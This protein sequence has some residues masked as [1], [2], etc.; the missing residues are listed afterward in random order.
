MC[1][2]D[3]T[4]RHTSKLISATQVV[5]NRRG[6]LQRF[7]LKTSALFA[8]SCSHWSQQSNLLR[9]QFQTDDPIMGIICK[10][11]CSLSCMCCQ[12]IIVDSN[13]A[14]TTV[15]N[16]GSCFHGCRIC[17]VPFRGQAVPNSCISSSQHYSLL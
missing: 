14:H 13:A 2:D 4:S 3:R 17:M 8:V 5:A 9:G 1:F 11:H 10:E 7:D 15:S 6:C 12:S 16:I